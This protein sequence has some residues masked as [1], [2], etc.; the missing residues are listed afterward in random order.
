[1]EAPWWGLVVTFMVAL[2]VV[3]ATVGGGLESLI[4]AWR[5]GGDR[6]ADD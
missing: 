4:K 1:M 3:W 6:K 5:Q 2:I